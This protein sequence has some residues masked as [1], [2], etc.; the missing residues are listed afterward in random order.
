M[1]SSRR[2]RVRGGSQVKAV[3]FSLAMSLLAASSA[4]AEVHVTMQDG[5][6]SIVARNATIRE[7]LM[8]WARV[9]HTK[10]VNVERLPG[11]PETLEL[12]DVTELQALDLLLRSLSGYIAVPRAIR[13]ANLSS[14]DRVVIMPTLATAVPAPAAVRAAASASSPPPPPPPVFQQ[15]PLVQQPVEDDQAQT[16]HDQNDQQ[17]VSSGIV[18]PQMNGV[19]PLNRSPVHS[20]EVAPQ[21]VVP[22]GVVPRPTVPTP[23]PVTNPSSPFAPVGGVAMPGMVAPAPPPG[24]P[25]RRPGGPQS[26]Q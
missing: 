7:I 13:A 10:I 15:E 23:T 9:G 14:I 18:L 17:P 8:E 5:R 24:Q 21:G 1:R 20:L 3:I 12:R 11:G 26:E 4:V 19:R 6:V 16:S 25:V 2:T 22:G